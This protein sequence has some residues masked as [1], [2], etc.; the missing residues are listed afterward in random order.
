M[1]DENKAP[2]VEADVVPEP[3]PELDVSVDAEA[4]TPAEAEAEAAPDEAAPTDEKPGKFTRDF[5]H[6]SYDF[7][8]SDDELATLREGTIRE[9]QTLGF[10]PTSAKVKKKS[11][12]TAAGVWS[13]RIV[14]E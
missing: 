12:D 8:A 3:E 7:H 9:A 13:V 6:S 14:A 2:D 4:D 10:R 1:T 11:L 5:T